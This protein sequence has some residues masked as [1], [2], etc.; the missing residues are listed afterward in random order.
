MV[1]LGAFIFVGCVVSSLA[2][3]ASG[4]LMIP[5][6]DWFFE[7]ELIFPIDDDPLH[8]THYPNLLMDTGYAKG[9]YNLG[10]G[11][12]PFAG[13]GFGQVD[14]LLEYWGFYASRRMLFLEVQ[15]TL[16]KHTVEDRWG[17]VA[18][19]TTTT[20]DRPLG[21]NWT[22]H[23]NISTIMR[24]STLGVITALQNRK[25]DVRMHRFIM[26]SVALWAVCRR[27]ANYLPDQTS[28][29]V[30]YAAAMKRWSGRKYVAYAGAL[31]VQAE[32]HYRLIESC[33]PQNH[34]EWCYSSRSDDT[35]LKSSRDLLLIGQSPTTAAR[36]LILYM[37]EG[38]KSGDYPGFITSMEI[39]LF[40][41]S[42]P[43][44]VNNSLPDKTPIVPRL[45]V[46]E[47]SISSKIESA[48]ITSSEI[49]FS[50]DFAD[51][52]DYQ[53]LA[54]GTK[55]SPHPVLFHEHWLDSISVITQNQTAQNRSLTATGHVSFPPRNQSII[56]NNP[57]L[58]LFAKTAITPYMLQEK[59]LHRGQQWSTVEAAELEITLGGAFASILLYLP[60]SDSQYALPPGVKLPDTFLPRQKFY[61]R[62]TNF[63]IQVYN[64]GYGYR[65]SSRT[66]KLGVVVLL[67]HAFIAL[68]G[69][70][71]QLMRWKVFTAWT[72]IP[73]YLA[74]GCGSPTGQPRLRNTGAGISGT[75][76]LQSVMRV[77]KTNEHLEI[78]ALEPAVDNS[79]DYSDKGLEI[80]IEE[81]RR[82][83]MKSP[84]SD[85]EASYG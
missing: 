52:A 48:T 13:L 25:N 1:F 46:I 54:N 4:V 9:E 35:I 34:P 27:V 77:Q 73:E 2:G 19:N 26:Y 85:V 17:R 56:T 3:P 53:I 38:P 62:A 41:R 78:L 55:E 67:A 44:S 24:E 36:Q 49:V 40:E 6:V 37:T 76:T 10:F 81:G 31:M 42:M 43:Q 72:T 69:S 23:T 33:L 32:C 84:L 82:P 50:S 15:N 20:W 65:L 29:N 45:G 14:R 7:K 22:G 83:S 70:L 21:G 59:L 5:R 61:D 68:L 16:T 64:Q 47:C 30:H 11:G 80:G 71:W 28:E 63:K 74:L 60:P 58:Q 8:G 39:I 57:T 79:G 66:G 18:I 75:R 51:F 12:D